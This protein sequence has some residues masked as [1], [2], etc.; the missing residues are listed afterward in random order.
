[1]RGRCLMLLALASFAAAASA[2]GPPVLAVVVAADRPVESL[3]V[4]DLGLVFKRKRQFWGDGQ[5]IQPVNLP[6]DHGLRRLFLR[7]VLRLSSEAQEDYWNEQYFH[8][9]LPPHVLRSEAAVARFVAETRG[10]IGYLSP[11]L[12]DARLRVL[13]VLDGEGRA[14]EPPRPGDC[15]AAAGGGR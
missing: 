5:R 1:M 10:G 11:C 14:V 6:P 3:Q 7:S 13:L 12:V 15:G 4:Q 9:V 8:G 2:A